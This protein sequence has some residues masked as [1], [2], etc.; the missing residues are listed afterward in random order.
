MI[1]FYLNLGRY[2]CPSG[3]HAWAKKNGGATVSEPGVA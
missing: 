2:L 1:K 3:E